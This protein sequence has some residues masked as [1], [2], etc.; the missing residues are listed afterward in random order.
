MKSFIFVASLMLTFVNIIK[1]DIN[2]Y[3]NSEQ[4][5]LIEDCFDLNNSLYFAIDLDK[6]KDLSLSDTQIKL[7]CYNGDVGKIGANDKIVKSTY[8]LCNADSDEYAAD[9]CREFVNSHMIRAYNK[10]FIDYAY[11]CFSMEEKSYFYYRELED[12]RY[13]Y[14]CL[15]KTNSTKFEPCFNEGEGRYC[16]YYYEKT[17][18]EAIDFYYKNLATDVVGD[19]VPLDILFPPSSSSPKEKRGEEEESTCVL[20]SFK[21]SF[22]NRRKRECPGSYVYS[23][24]DC[25]NH[26]ACIVRG[27]YDI[28]AETVD[29]KRL[30]E[31]PPR[32]IKKDG[33]V[34]CVSFCR[35][36]YDA[37]LSVTLINPYAFEDHRQDNYCIYSTSQMFEV[38][39]GTYNIRAPINSDSE[40][41]FKI[42]SVDGE[43]E[44]S[45]Y[46]SLGDKPVVQS[47]VPVI[48]TKVIQITT[49]KVI[50]VATT[51]VIEVTETSKPSSLD[52]KCAGKYAQCGGIGYMDHPVVNQ[53]PP[54]VNSVNT[55]H[56]VN[57]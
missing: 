29:D 39:K 43:I 22:I 16:N 5:Q 10:K 19:N 14:V 40:V 46:K 47:A 26:Y 17:P 56:N 55:T 3:I 13:A 36:H 27:K 33:D 6:G 30:L 7:V 4:K 1:A 53:V 54:A 52:E 34:Y 42:T 11:D 48:S 35:N 24:M 2:Y 49:T 32:C 9:A 21:A 12:G 15:K 23:K 51:K 18:S 38:E 57:K 41:V 50:P 44:T 8:P 25:E 37:N 31:E 20:P 45:H 28:P